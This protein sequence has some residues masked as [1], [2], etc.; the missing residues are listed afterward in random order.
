LNFKATVTRPTKPATPQ[1]A[2]F[3]P[4]CEEKDQRYFRLVFPRAAAVAVKPV[5]GGCDRPTHVGERGHR[6]V[7]GPESP[8]DS[9]SIQG[10]Q[11]YNLSKNVRYGHEL[12]RK[13]VRVRKRTF[14]AG[15][16][17]VRS[18]L[19]AVPAASSKEAPMLKRMEA[20]H[21]V[22]EKVQGEGSIEG[23]KVT[24]RL[25]LLSE[26]KQ[27]FLDLEI[28]DAGDTLSGGA[29]ATTAE[30]AAR[31]GS[32]GG[33][34]TSRDHGRRTPRHACH[35][36]AEHWTG[37]TERRQCGPM[38]R[39]ASSDAGGR[40]PLR[41]VTPIGVAFS[42]VAMSGAAL[43]P[44]M[45]PVLERDTTQVPIHQGNHAEGRL[46]TRL[47][48]GGLVGSRSALAQPGGLG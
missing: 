21:V 10:Y 42:R 46:R 30:T 18:W 45:E 35:S 5:D 13:S 36:P 9:Q 11:F 47:P 16:R 7:R 23:N 43:K 33:H 37:T 4:V 14:F 27:L 44:R 29:P 40:V 12:N 26:R 22:A 8:E 38:S 39:A 32:I 17:A 28:T 31:S 24:I 41:L 25:M 1:G 20:T 19:G 15:Q 34:P 6:R 48:E 3:C 2:P